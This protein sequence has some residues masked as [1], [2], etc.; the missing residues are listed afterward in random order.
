MWRARDINL[1]RDVALKIL[2]NAHAL[3]PGRLACFR[4]S[5]QVLASLDHPDIGLRVRTLG[6]DARGLV[7]E[8]HC[9]P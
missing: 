9:G 8:P 4:W 5:T 1:N 6:R 7:L 3:D 2:L